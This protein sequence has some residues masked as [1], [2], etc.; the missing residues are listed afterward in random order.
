MENYARHVAPFNAPGASMQA[1]FTPRSTVNAVYVS[2]K[3]LK[4]VSPHKIIAECQSLG[5][6]R[7]LGDLHFALEEA[8]ARLQELNLFK[9]VSADI[10]V[11]PNGVVD[12]TFN[13]EE[14]AREISVSGNVDKKGEMSCDVRVVQPALLGGPLSASGSVG[15]T[16]SQAREFVLRL[17]TPRPLGRR[18]GWSFEVARSSSEETQASSYSDTV[19]NAVMKV[20]DE[21]GRHSVSL[22]GAFRDL[23]PSTS[24]H[25]LPSSEIQ[26]AR[27]RSVKTSVSYS[28]M[29]HWESPPN[30]LGESTDAHLRSN[31]E[32]AGGLG[33]VNFV[34]GETHAVATCRLPWRF[35][36]Q[37]S[38]AFGLLMPTDSK[39]SCF[40]DRFFLGGAS[41]SSL[42]CKGFAYR[43]F[44][45]MGV[46]FPRD[47]GKR[48]ERLV[49]ALG[50]DMMLNM[51]LAI[52]APVWL[53][54]GFLQLQRGSSRA[55]IDA[56]IFCFGGVSSLAEAPPRSG[57]L[58]AVLE[59]LQSGAR[60]AV[61]VGISTPLAG[62]GSLEFTFAHPFWLQRHDLSQRWQLGLRMNLSA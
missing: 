62:M 4:R 28:F 37:A 34:K 32:V 16:A 13:V 45:P 38:G 55:G 56:R 20:D 49:D 40:Q 22:E 59:N 30:P 51:N 14:K 19:T 18:C 52:S 21:S 57:F 6:V 25:R 46:C 15:S 2:F 17:S 44:G 61:G 24:G 10:S 60:A 39:P 36:A 42:I 47:P 50:S 7:S 58:P 27:L 26:Q 29:R 9:A 1:L 33:D 35:L 3:G 23:Y 12:V 53:P 43:G 54:A 5:N 8:D 31:I 48:G 41:G 11:E